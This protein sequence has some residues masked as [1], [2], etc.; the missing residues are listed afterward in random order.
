MELIVT[1]SRPVAV[2]D[3]GWDVDKM[4]D[5]DQKVQTSHYKIIKF[6]VI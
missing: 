3:G 5:G 4:G 6:G 2:R 1:E